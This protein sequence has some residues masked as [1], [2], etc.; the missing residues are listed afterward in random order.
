MIEF[1]QE[2]RWSIQDDCFI[3]DALLMEMGIEQIDLL[4]HLKF[5]NNGGIPLHELEK[6]HLLKYLDEYY[7]EP[8][9]SDE[10]FLAFLIEREKEKSLKSKKKPVAVKATNGTETER[11]M[12]SVEVAKD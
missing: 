6:E 5:L 2:T 9:D 3:V 12:D 8:T 4:S 10:P 1:D 7:F 11:E